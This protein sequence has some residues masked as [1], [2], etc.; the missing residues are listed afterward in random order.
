[1]K[2]ENVKTI[3]VVGAG[4][5]G[6]QIGTLCAMHGYE[7]YVT[8]ANP[9]QLARA[10]AFVDDYLPG[11][12]AK[13]RITQ[14]EADKAA[15]LIHFESDMAVAAKNADVVIEAV[16]EEIGLKRRIFSQLEEICKEDCVFATNASSLPSS[17]IAAVLKNPGRICNMHFFNPA[18][19]MKTVE[20]MR[21]THTSDDA[22]NTV[23]AL[24]EKLEKTPARLQKEI[25]GMVGSRVCGVIFNLGMELVHGGY[26]T[27]E[28]VDAICRGALGHPMGPFALMDLTG[29]DMTYYAQ[30]DRFRESG[31]KDD[32]PWPLMAEMC[33]RGEFGRKCGRGFY[34]YTEDGKMIPRDDLWSTVD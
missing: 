29:V 34:E 10:K 14:E 20:V 8:D 28:D 27:V 24:C 13:G 11:R 33:A 25:R 18:L 9:A 6:H 5:M 32:L 31:D 30:L 1:M 19:V 16:Y 2:I 7:T 22:F 4:N 3:T 12:V 21:G 15:A 17:E 23:C 26:A